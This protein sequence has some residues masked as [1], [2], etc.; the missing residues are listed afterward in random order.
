MISIQELSVAFA[1]ILDDECFKDKERFSKKNTPYNILAPL[2]SKFRIPYVDICTDD[3]ALI[4]KRHV[5]PVVFGLNQHLNLRH[6]WISHPIDE[7]MELAHSYI[8]VRHKHDLLT[9]D[10]ILAIRINLEP[11]NE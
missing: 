1:K 4:I 8:E 2:A 3:L 11:V 5:A 7:S 10:Y 6:K 9:S